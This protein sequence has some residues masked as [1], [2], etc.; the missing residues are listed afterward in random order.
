MISAGFSDLLASVGEKGA[1]TV[2]GMSSL[3][4]A[5]GVG[6]TDVNVA[7]TGFGG[8]L[9]LMGGETKEKFMSGVKMSAHPKVRGEYVL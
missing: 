8:L 2:A 7:S 1:M 6:G 5:I 4:A 3:L 9:V